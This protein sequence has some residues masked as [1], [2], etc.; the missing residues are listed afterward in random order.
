MP[1]SASFSASQNYGLPS[2][3]KLTDTSTGSD[4]SIASRRVYLTKQ[5]GS[6]LVPSGTT[7]DYIVWLYA[8]STISIDA[9]DKD[10]SLNVVVQWLDSDGNV[11]YT[12]SQTYG[13]TLYNEQFLYDL[14]QDQTSNYTIIQDAN[15]Y[16]NKMQMRVEIDSGDQA[17]E[18]AND[19]AGAQ[20][21]YD[22]ATAFRL[23][24]NIYF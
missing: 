23:S 24:Q 17:I 4:A 18:L 2:V 21:C 10:Y 16:N 9:L 1:L 20:G 13:F 15:Y 5:N 6:F 12:S 3:I 14:T 7:T 19:I 8:N 22:R 11:L